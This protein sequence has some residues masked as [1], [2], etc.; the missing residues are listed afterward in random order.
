M[1][2][3]RTIETKARR[4]MDLLQDYVSTNRDSF[5]NA[6]HCAEAGVTEMNSRYSIFFHGAYCLLGETGINSTNMYLMSIM[7]EAI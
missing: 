6:G 5:N 1:H 4:Q 2:S 7:C 3:G